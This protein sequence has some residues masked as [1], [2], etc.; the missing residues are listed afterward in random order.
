M[1]ANIQRMKEHEAEAAKLLEAVPESS[2]LWV[3]ARINLGELAIKARRALGPR[4]SFAPSPG[5]IPPRFDRDS[6]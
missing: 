1:L 4:R 3:P 2:L 6:A 5:V